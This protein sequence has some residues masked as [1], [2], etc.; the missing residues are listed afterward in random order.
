MVKPGPKPKP[1]KVKKLKGNPGKRALPKN[2][3]Q[4][5]VPTIVPK[6][7][8][9]LP[10]GAKKIWRKEAPK[11]I[12]LGVLSELDYKAF[13]MCCLVLW[14]HEEAEKQ[15]KKA[16]NNT[17]EGAL[18]TTPSGY[19]EYSVL[20]NLSHKSMDLAMKYLAEFG[21]TPSS[22]SRIEV[23]K[24][25]RQKNPRKEGVLTVIDDK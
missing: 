22:R 8:T 17:L 10:S 2:E 5:G 4:P 13:S 24:P 25:P 16:G 18:S 20:L 21:M 9:Y 6:P 14:R 3:P 11:L 12:R 1:T 15:M 19:Q 7:P 23:R